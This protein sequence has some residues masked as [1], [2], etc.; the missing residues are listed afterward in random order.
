MSDPTPNDDGDPEGQAGPPDR[1][2][3]AEGGASAGVGAAGGEAEGEAP[4]AADGVPSADPAGEAGEGDPAGGEGEGDPAGEADLAGVADEAAASPGGGAAKGGNGAG[5]LDDFAEAAAVLE[6]ASPLE[7]LLR[8]VRAQPGFCLFL[9]FLAVGVPILVSRLQR[10]MVVQQVD[11]GLDAWQVDLE[12]AGVPVP[13]L[14]PAEV[15]PPQRLRGVPEVAYTSAQRDRRG[16]LEAWSQLVAGRAPTQLGDGKGPVVSGL[17][18]CWALRRA[19]QE[20]PPRPLLLREGRE[21]ARHAPEA[22]RQ[23]LLLAEGV[24][25]GRQRE[26]LVNARRLLRTLEE[27]QGH[28]DAHPDLVRAAVEAEGERLGQ[29]MRLGA[30][31]MDR[32]LCVL[33]ILARLY[34]EGIAESPARAAWAG[35]LPGAGELAGGYA[36]RWDQDPALLGEALA[37]AGRLDPGTELIPPA[38]FAGWR[39]QLNGVVD[40]PARLRGFAELLAEA[41]WFPSG[42][43]Q[44]LVSHALER[45][46]RRGPEESPGL[47]ARLVDLGFEAASPEPDPAALQGGL[48][49]VLNGLGARVDRVGQRQRAWAHFALARG[50]AAAGQAEEAL[51]AAATAESLGFEPRP[52][53]LA[54]RARCLVELERTEEGLA[55]ARERMT[56]LETHTARA[57]GAKPAERLPWELRGYPVEEVALARLRSRAALDLARLLLGA[58]GLD[59][60]Q[61][62]CDRAGQLDP[63]NPWVPFVR[64]RIL[65]AQGRIGEAR[66]VVLRSLQGVSNNHDETLGR[67]LRALLKELGPN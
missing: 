60:A 37:M 11:Q 15:P 2:S 63:R 50:L 22:W 21:E 41:G 29:V 14:P 30:P 57:R 31:D 6:E 54:L 35:V 34:P 20:D 39:E 64:A 43:D 25:A 33:R 13:F 28:T 53:L 67:Q 62:A 4:P 24:L 8:R 45:G 7:P 18:A 38:T 19:A 36:G 5:A 61:E 23:T 58:G 10:K 51:A 52:S 16:D 26:A 66:N 65:Q 49:G 47:G 46:G 59:E 56:A 48:E 32:C 17:R 1:A 40:D 55:A 27:L 44:I 12:A 9:I 42:L 3:E